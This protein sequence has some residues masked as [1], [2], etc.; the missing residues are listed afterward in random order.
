[1]LDRYR[2]YLHESLNIQQEEPLFSVHCEGQN[3]ILLTATLASKIHFK[4]NHW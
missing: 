4:N 1:M 2:A 3:F